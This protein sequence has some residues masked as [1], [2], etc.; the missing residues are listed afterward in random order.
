MLRKDGQAVKGQDAAFAIHPA[1]TGFWQ[2]RG[3]QTRLM[4]V[5]CSRLFVF[6]GHRRQIVAGIGQAATADTQ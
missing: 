2:D 1:D 4:A 3:Q 5:V 6:W